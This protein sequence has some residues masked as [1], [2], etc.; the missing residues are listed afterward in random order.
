MTAVAL[1]C[2]AT[3]I[4][5]AAAQT[6]NGP[7]SASYTSFM[8][9]YHH[10]TWYRDAKFGM[11]AHW[12]PQCQPGQGDWYARNLYLQGSGQN[13][14]HVA[15]YG[16]PSV[17]GFKDICNLW[18]A[19]NWNPD[20]LLQSYTNA[21][22]KFFLAMAN[23]HDN[24]DTWD[25]KYQPWNSVAIGPKKDLIGGWS[26]AAHRAG[27]P[28]GVTVHAARAWSWYEVAQGADTNGAYLGVP[29][30]G[31]MTITNGAGL[32]WSGLEPQDLYAQNH[33]IGAATAQAYSDKYYNRV[34]DLL[35]NYHPDLLYFDDSGLPLGQTGLNIA[36]YY[37]NGFARAN[38]GKVDVIITA[39]QLSSDQAR[40]ITYDIE[41]GT[42]PGL[43]L[44]PWQSENCIGSWHYKS[45]LTY[46]TSAQV[47]G[48]LVDT[49]SKN[50]TFVINI[51]VAGD[52]TIDSAEQTFVSQMA[53]WMKFGGEAV[54]KTRP[55]SIFGEGTNNPAGVDAIAFKS[56]DLRFTTRNGTLYGFGMAWP[57]NSQYVFTTLGS[58]S[59]FASGT[60]T[61]VQLLG[62]AGSLTWTR[63]A[64]NLVVNVPASAPYTGKYP[65]RI[66]GTLMPGAPLS[67]NT[68]LEQDL[69]AVSPAG[70]SSFFADTNL[71][72]NRYT[73]MGAGGDIGGTQDACHFVYHPLDGNGEIAARV[74][75]METTDAGAK[76]G[77]MIRESLAPNAKQVMLALTPEQ[78]LTLLSRSTTGGAT[79]VQSNLAVGATCRVRLVRNGSIFTGYYSIG[80]QSWIPMNLAGIAMSNRV[81]VGMAVC[82]RTNGTLC[83]GTFDKV[84][85]PLPLFNT[86]ASGGA[87]TASKDNPPNETAA[88]A[89]DGSTATK[90]FNAS[91]G[92][93][94]WLQIQ[95]TN[96]IARM[97]AQYVVAS[98]NDVPGRD[99]KNWQLLGSSNGTAWAALDTQSNQVFA[100]RYQANT[101]TITNPASCLYFRLNITAN[102]GDAAGLQLSELQLLVTNIGAPPLI[103]V[104]ADMVIQAP[105][106]AGAAV[107]FAT[108]ATNSA[109]L[110]LAV[111]N[112]PA[113]GSTF[114]IGVNLVIASA[115][116]ADGTPSS[117]TFLVTVTSPAPVI[118]R[119]ALSGTGMVVSG[120]NGIAG[121]N[122]R[123]LASTNL[124]LP[125]AG[126]TSV[127]TNQCGTNGSFI[128]SLNITNGQQKFYRIV[129]P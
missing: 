43:M 19:E 6:T 63:S 126:W 26:A 61:N 129:S 35:D 57:T 71:N 47:L 120:T 30:D 55:W 93:N 76:A 53:T 60:V 50:G 56:T 16:H 113:S 98:A 15:H 42:A 4:L 107:N 23:H 58:N 67:T 102:S 92:T 115:T 24:F 73:I 123:I 5:S 106:P 11:W 68:W 9:G 95:F 22:A 72:I 8:Q 44:Y 108:T 65:F 13:V 29:Y 97:P 121:S 38:H 33:V 105:S 25:S 2:L 112:Q 99:P 78:G 41:R 87:T 128:F 7:F 119:A 3:G 81:Y 80:E 109:G 51:P 124:A 114:P 88:K 39:K 32:W 46:K 116:D 34:Q 27:L 45:N 90:W 21:G 91:G 85:E 66:S 40:A 96:G 74:L 48:Y 127:A 117:K 54:F 37:Y 17:F 111:A 110:P 77:V 69:G 83:A 31:T 36:A 28:F 1:A 18:H 10:P 94:G 59:A 118:S 14:Y 89:F 125:L 62:Y 104:P 75:W 12:G 20:Q 122:Y 64:S 82:S 101:Y 100:A 84:E 86:A 103:G 52:G 49:V 79:V 70:R